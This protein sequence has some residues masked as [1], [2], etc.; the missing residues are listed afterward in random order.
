MG[1]K[2]VNNLTLQ[3]SADISNSTSS[4]PVVSTAGL[5]TLGVGDWMYLT[6]A[7]IREGGELRWEVVKLNNYSSNV[8]SVTRGQDGTTGQAWLAGSSVSNRVTAGDMQELE[9]FKD[10]SRSITL[11]GDVVGTVSYTG[12]GSVSIGTTIASTK[13]APVTSPALT[14]TPTAPTAAAGTNTTQLATTEFVT[15]A[16]NNLQSQING[17]VGLTGNQT[18]AGQKVFS[19]D[20]I[21]N[22]STNDTPSFRVVDPT[23][24]STFEFDMD[25]EIPRFMTVY[26]GGAV[27]IPLT[28]DMQTGSV[29]LQGVSTAT[30]APAG[31]STT[32]VATTA[33]VTAADN[34]L[35]SQIN[36]KVGLTGNQTI[37]GIKTFSDTIVLNNN[38][39]DAPSFKLVD[40]VNNTTCE[41][42]MAL[43]TPRFFGSYRG[44]AFT[45]PLM[46]NMQT[47]S[48]ILQ[49]TP[50]APTAPAGTK[51]TQVATT[52]FVVSE[53]GGRRNYLING[54]FD[55]WDY[56]TS[57]T[58]SGYGS[59]NRW[60]N[61]NS[62]STKTHS[63]I[64]CG[65]TERALFNAMYY[66][67]TVVSSVAGSANWV[68]KW[69]NIENINLLAGKTVTL[70]F[71]ARADA[72]RNIAI[73]FIQSTGTGGNPSPWVINI[74]SQLVSL[75]TTWN[76]F[77]ITVT[78]PSVVG[79][80][81]GTDG[82]HTTFTGFTFWFDAGSDLATR[83]ANLGQQS[84]TFDI[85]QVKL[86]DGSVAT[87]G[88][89]PYDGEFGGEVAACERYYRPIYGIIAG[90]SSGSG[91]AAGYGM[92]IPTM[93]VSPSVSSITQTTTAGPIGAV[94][95]GII[96]ANKVQIIAS[97]TGSGTF[98][99]EASAWL[100]AEL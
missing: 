44:G 38:T 55:K 54:N 59:D 12:T 39:N 57:Q 6:L 33:F 94:G 56:A 28:F 31:T 49:G 67:R 96:S 61:G 23:N 9:N 16:D 24:N 27:K 87:N 5:P 93:R 40:P 41:W 2:F 21:L 52:E 1:Q 83:S 91:M 68:Q 8:I 26:R 47:G 97:S 42:D 73:E 13:F 100:S 46:F 60:C 75:S 69:Q 74:G 25:V 30:T 36:G 29:N 77:S 72:N 79:K 32:Q 88:W 14:G 86:E 95:F 63:Q 20:I 50:T 35:Q 53:K 62:G 89:H 84:G 80:T 45:F 92:V 70:S 90:Y 48:A 11:T 58:F 66:S 19:S 43:E 3:T 37:A 18:I 10:A 98:I 81:L 82:A 51:T 78:L 34:N 15:S 64:A 4:I 85:A 7:D 76:R 65:D 17:K 99:S 71:W 22:N